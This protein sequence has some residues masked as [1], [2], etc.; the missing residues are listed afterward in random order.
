MR[1]GIKWLALLAIVPLAMACSDD[2]GGD[3][4]DA[5]TVTDK[6]GGGDG[7]GASADSTT[8]SDGGGGATDGGGVAQSD[9]G[10]GGGGDGGAGATDGGG[11]GKLTTCT[12][13]GDCVV[14]A[15]APVGFKA[16][17]SDK[18][19]G[20]AVEPAALAK[21]APALSCVNDTCI[22]KVCKD[23]KDPKCL[24]DCLGD[25]CIGPILK[26]LDDG[27]TGDKPCPAVGPCMDG[28]GLGTPD[29][30]KCMNKC[31]NT[32]T[33]DGKKQVMALGDCV[34]KEGGVDKCFG[35][36][37]VCFT[38]GKT[39]DKPCG[40]I[41]G[42]IEACEKKA[43]GENE[44]CVFEC[45]AQVDKEAQ[46]LF[47]QMGKAGCFPDDEGGGKDKPP[48]PECLGLMF[49]CALHKQSGDL[50]CHEVFKCT[51]GCV[52]EEVKKAGG[53]VPNDKMNEIKGICMMGCGGKLK[54]EVQKAFLDI[55]PCMGKD[56]DP[57]CVAK[58][59][60]CVAPSGKATC[61]ETGGCI[62]KCPEFT[63]ESGM[64]SCA[65]DCLHN[66]TAA[67]AT[68]M[69][70]AMGLCENGPSKEC[71]DQATKCGG[72]STGKGDCTALKVCIGGCSA[73][74]GEKTLHCAVNCWPAHTA[75]ATKTFA[76]LMVCDFGCGQECGGKSDEKACK[77]KCLAD[78]C[79]A[80]AAACPDPK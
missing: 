11:G 41:S 72:A 44:G 31:V 35:E 62:A 48:T 18:C 7:G 9:G 79:A 24:D 27:K 22:A 37:L 45:L 30:F 5:G 63:S 60:A 25:K 52:V 54:Q 78:K 3:K 46:G 71:I 2:G 23:S 51:E 65:Y 15:C 75:D 53:N 49:Q 47:G 4:K 70:A 13:V 55:V 26:C 76:D 33:G 29:P 6:D 40:F 20:D 32:L 57:A 67:A 19:L 77:D 73:G 38:A 59:L 14:K 1:R 36:A 21:A 56:D 66:A 39:G 42:C 10:G 17:C 43:G 74:S 64:N 16:G 12:E 61:S 69:L 80:F 34:A 8:A 68:D 50:M 58:L 28:C